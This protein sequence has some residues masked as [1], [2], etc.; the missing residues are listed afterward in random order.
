MKAD[1]NKTP[2]ETADAPRGELMKCPE[3]GGD[4]FTINKNA[5]MEG[6][7]WRVPVP[8]GEGKCV[9][10][11]ITDPGGHDFLNMVCS[12]CGAQFDDG[13]IMEMWE[14]GGWWD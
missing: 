14:T 1:E 2:P 13:E 8:W 4:E 7:C 3:C 10:V 6:R 9:R 12:N 5:A 11:E